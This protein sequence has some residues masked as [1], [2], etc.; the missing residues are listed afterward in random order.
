MVNVPDSLPARM[1]LLAHDPR[2]Q[3]MTAGSRLGYVLRAAALTELF[4]DGRLLDERKRAVPGTPGNDPYG[5]LAQIASSRPRTW[6]HWVRKDSRAMKRRVQ[7]ELVDAGLIRVQEHRVLGVFPATRVTVRDPRVVKSLWRGA[8]SALWG[9]PV[10]H[11]NSLDAAVVALA[12]A[13]EITT[14]LPRSERRRHKRRIAD[15]SARSGPAPKAVRKV[16]EANT[17]AAAA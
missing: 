6:Q 16:I 7:S 11:V 10:A 17:A 2:R 3:R 12:A 4:L 9:Q 1:Y 13:G 14:F 5:L 15:L 8:S